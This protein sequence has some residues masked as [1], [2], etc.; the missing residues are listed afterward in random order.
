MCSSLGRQEREP[1][2]SPVPTR[3]NVE[4]AKPPCNL[5]PTSSCATI[6]YAY[7]TYIHSRFRTL[8]MY[9][10]TTHPTL[11]LQYCL[12]RLSPPGRWALRMKR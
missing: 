7:M 4:F 5:D 11:F 1:L 3:L 2:A 8:T 12:R 9:Q 6:R 10:P